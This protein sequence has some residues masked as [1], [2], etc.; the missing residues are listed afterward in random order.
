MPRCKSS[1][2]FFHKRPPGRPAALVAGRDEFNHGHHIAGRVF[3]DD[4]IGFADIGVDGEGL[5]IRISCNHREASLRQTTPIQKVHDRYRPR[6]VKVVEDT[7]FD[8]APVV[9]RRGGY[10]GR[11]EIGAP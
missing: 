2:E 7:R 1:T 11:Y 10:L 9:N 5:M 4:A 8:A 6:L 3:H